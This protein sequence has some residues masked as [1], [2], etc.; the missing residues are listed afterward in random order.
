[1]HQV[2]EPVSSHSVPRRGPH[3]KVEPAL[4]L[5]LCL[6]ACARPAPGRD[7]GVERPDAGVS[8]DA[9]QA[10][11]AGDHPC[12]HCSHG[13]WCE[14]DT[15]VPECA[16]CASSGDCV[17]GGT[18]DVR[19]QCVFLAPGCSGPDVE[20]V[21]ASIASAW[22][23]LD[24]IDVLELDVTTGRLAKT[25]TRPSDAG[26]VTRDAGVVFVVAD[27]W[28]TAR[29]WC[30]FPARMETCAFD[31]PIIDVQVSGGG[32]THGF[33]YYAGAAYLPEVDPL[34]IDLFRRF[35]QLT[36]DGG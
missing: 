10:V 33:S 13:T 26:V 36:A 6:G 25:V 30:P 20:S 12:L 11:D 19:G 16:P 34:V 21:R 29:A 23:P 14:R 31:L 27:A 4:I 17:D 3:S 28:R 8:A 7:A 22:C 1:M 32:S 5:A 24:C 9:G 15:C 2:P 18:C 35:D